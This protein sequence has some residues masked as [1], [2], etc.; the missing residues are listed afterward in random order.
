[1]DQP[2]QENDTEHELLV[3]LL[4]SLILSG[5]NSHLIPE[6]FNSGPVFGAFQNSEPEL[7]GISSVH[8]QYSP[9]I[10]VSA[11]LSPPRLNPSGVIFNIPSSRNIRLNPE[12]FNSW[13][14]VGASR[15]YEPELVCISSVH[16]QYPPGIPV[17]VILSPPRLNP[18]GV[19]FNIPNSGQQ[20]ESGLVLTHM[21][22]PMVQSVLN[23]GVNPNRVRKAIE[24]RL[25]ETGCMYPNAEALLNAVLNFEQN[26]E[27]SS[28]D[29]GPPDIPKNA[30][31]STPRS[32]E[33]RRSSSAPSS[34]L[35]KELL[36]LRQKTKCKVCLD[37]EVGVVF[38]PCGHLCCCQTCAPRVQNCPVCRGSI[39]DRVRTYMS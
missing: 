33:N 7:I 21:Q 28:L 22:S 17:S 20:D 14:V 35:E 24:R 12:A 39:Q 1:M 2:T 13:P 25:R 34:D 19:I 27:S 3:H 37:S 32:N 8:D 6:P 15:T 36:G 4:S 10:P 11:I 18:S 23:T 29:L 9:G 16:D 30:L 5:G 31:L 38:R 26:R